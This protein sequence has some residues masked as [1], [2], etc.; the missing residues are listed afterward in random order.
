MQQLSPIELQLVQ[1]EMQLKSAA[2]IAFLLDVPVDQI[3]EAI[4]AISE[5][6]GISSKQ[7]AIDAKEAAKPVKVPKPKIEKPKKVKE[8]K[9]SSSIIRHNVEQA[10]KK[11][12]EKVESNRFKKRE[13]DYSQMMSVKIDSKTYIWIKKNEDPAVAI[14]NWKKSLKAHD[15]YTS[16]F[17]KATGRQHQ[18]N[19]SLK[20]T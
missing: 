8:P 19:A 20:S 2:D 17:A 12:R 7:A 15:E 1:K 18:I 10:I 9:I 14:A 5:E 11:K 16:D 4:A 13:V 3:R 6:S